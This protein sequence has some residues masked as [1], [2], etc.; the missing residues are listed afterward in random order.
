M[1]DIHRIDEMVWVLHHIVDIDRLQLVHINILNMWSDRFQVVVFV[2]QFGFA[3]NILNCL[4][5]TN[6]VFSSTIAI[7]ALRALRLIY[8]TIENLFSMLVF[9]R[10]MTLVDIL[11]GV[12]GFQNLIKV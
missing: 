8:Q 11:N 7:V 1:E 3:Q 5:L 10:L 4:L 2:C 12:V 9:K 6:C